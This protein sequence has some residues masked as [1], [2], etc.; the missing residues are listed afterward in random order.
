[1]AKAKTVTRAHF[2][3]SVFVTDLGNLGSSLPSNGRTIDGL[4]MSTSDEGLVVEG[5]WR[6]KKAKAVIPY[7]NIVI[8]ELDPKD[9]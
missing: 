6:G 7:A 8:M 3:Q 9:E 5:S 2:H 4:K 1:M